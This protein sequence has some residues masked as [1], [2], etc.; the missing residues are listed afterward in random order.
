MTSRRW[1]LFALMGAGLSGCGAIGRSRF[2]PFNWFGSEEEEL[3]PLEVEEERRPLVREI[4]SLAVERTPGGAIVRATALPP[5][6]GW[7]APE[8]ISLDPDGQPIEGVLSYSF[9]AVPPEAP[10]RQSTA[11]SRE[12]SAAVFITET[13]LNRVRVIRVTGAQNSRIARR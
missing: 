2:N 5:T 6:Q 4:T 13:V 8:L 10:T 1:V 7:F 11:R 9:R 12:L 3:A